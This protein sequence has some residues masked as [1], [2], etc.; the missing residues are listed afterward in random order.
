MRACMHTYI[1]TYTHMIQFLKDI[2]K[3]A[4]FNMKESTK[5]I[6]IDVESAMLAAEHRSGPPGSRV[7][8]NCVC[9][10]AYTSLYMYV[11]IHASMPNIE[12]ATHLRPSILQARLSKALCVCVCLTKGEGMCV[13][14][15]AR[16]CD[17]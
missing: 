16:V 3:S 8:C 10:H 4:V 2:M 15:C 5:R 1:H 6:D 14:V 11:H 7:S 9:V 12:S 17:S 13:A